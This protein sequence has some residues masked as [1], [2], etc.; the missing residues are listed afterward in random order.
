V[1]RAEGILREASL[2]GPALEVR[3]SITAKGD[4]ASLRLRDVVSNVGPRPAPCL[5]LYHINTGWPLLDDGAE[6]ILPGSLCEP[7]DADAEEGGADWMRMHAPASGYREKVYFH[8]IR[9]GD[10]GW[11][12]VGVINRRL[13]L[14]LRLRYRPVELPYFT[15]WKMLGEQEYTLGIEPGTCR[16][17]GRE[18]ERAAG[19]LVDLAPGERIE[20]GFELDVVEG[21]AA[22]DALA[23]EASGDRAA[24]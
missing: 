2:F 8:T 11:A 5:L 22:L 16:P 3:R 9:A 13:G 18:A 24:S 10:G 14:G 23:R 15:E 1:L 4:G 17:L 6:L 19:R 20:T 21:G 7:R 12:T